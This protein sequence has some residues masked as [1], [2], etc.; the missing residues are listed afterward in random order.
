MSVFERDKLPT[1]NGKHYVLER[2]AD[3]GRHGWWQESRFESLGPGQARPYADTTKNYRL[4]ITGGTPSTLKGYDLPNFKMSDDRLEEEAQ[5]HAGWT[6]TK[7]DPERAWHESYLS[8]LTTTRTD[9]WV[10]IEWT[11]VSPYLD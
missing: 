3:L 5:H 10:R 11:I 8:Q 4:T 9:Q 6:R 2:P 1:P 7:D